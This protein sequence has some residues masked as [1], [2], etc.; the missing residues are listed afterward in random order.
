MTTLHSTNAQRLDALATSAA[1]TTMAE[2]FEGAKVQKINQL[3][4]T[5]FILQLWKPNPDRTPE[6]DRCW[7]YLHLNKQNPIFCMLTNDELK[8]VYPTTA[9][10]QTPLLMILRK[11]L[12]GARLDGVHSLDGE[13]LLDLRFNYSTELGFRSSVRVVIEFMGKYSNLLLLDK[14]NKILGLLNIVDEDQ[15]RLRPL[16]VSG[17]YNNP[18][19]P[20]S[21]QPLK[22]LVILSGAEGSPKL[23]EDSLQSDYS[24][25]KAFQAIKDVG[26]GVSKPQLMPLL[27]HAASWDEAVGHVRDLVENYSPCMISDD[28]DRADTRPAPTGIFGYAGSSVGQ[29]AST[30]MPSAIE[31]LAG[32]YWPWKQSQIMEQSRVHLRRPLRDRHTLLQQGIDR[33]DEEAVS[34][35]ALEELKSIGDLL[36]TLH[37]MLHFTSKNPFETVYRIDFNPIGVEIPDVIAVDPKKTWLDNAQMY[38]KKVGKGKGRNAYARGERERFMNRLHHIETLTVL[39]ENAQNMAD[40]QALE[41]DWRTSGLLP[42]LKVKKGQKPQNQKASDDVGTLTMESPDGLRILVGK[43]AKAN[44]QLIAKHLK[45]KDWWLHSG[46]NIPGSHVVVKVQGTIYADAPLP[47]PTL[48]MAATLAAWFSAGQ[49]S[50][51]VP[52]MYTRGKYVR[53]IPN[54]WPGHVTHTNEESVVMIP[55]NLVSEFHSG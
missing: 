1:A 22:Q 3:G 34:E 17:T 8:T 2:R 33:L 29:S 43:S 47:L 27:D 46:E 20:E 11:Y 16:H 42:E 49:E 53:A 14:E 4:P 26:W 41:S 13:P 32:Y 54:S 48:E 51:K 40:V 18:P 12:M 23:L 39:L 50:A 45:A 38:Y 7:L 30:P 36:M 25:K 21:K 44:G 52:V 5:E 55:K 15:S 37:S 35:Q 24:P 28:P 9:N 19:R 10:H 6:L 31:M